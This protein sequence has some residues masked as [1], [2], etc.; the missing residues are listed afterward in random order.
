[1]RTDDSE[2]KYSST[3]LDWVTLDTNIAYWLHPRTSVSA[4]LAPAAV[5]RLVPRGPLLLAASW[6]CTASSQRPVT[7]CSLNTSAAQGRYSRQT[8]KR[9][10]TPACR[11]KPGSST[12]MWRIVLF[13]Q[14]WFLK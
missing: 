11:R 1:M 10:V 4:V 8:P 14:K 5:S 6:L 3:P 13:H 9:E 2:H 7:C 12:F